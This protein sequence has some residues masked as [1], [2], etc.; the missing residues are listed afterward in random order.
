MEMYANSR[1]LKR[2]NINPNS[3]EGVGEA[4]RPQK[5]GLFYNFLVTRSNFIKLSDFF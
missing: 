4:K 3:P 1:H 5:C 2:W